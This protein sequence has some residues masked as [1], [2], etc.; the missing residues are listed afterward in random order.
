MRSF[1]SGV[2]WCFVLCT[3][4]VVQGQAEAMA[5]GLGDV[6]KKAFVMGV[7][8]PDGALSAGEW[9][10]LTRHFHAVTP[11][12][13]MKPVALQPEEGRF[14]W[15]A[16]D[17]LV[18]EADRRKLRVNG[19]V[20]VWHEQCP[21]WFFQQGD[22]EAPREQVLKR[23]REHVAAVVGRYAGKIQSWDVV[24]EALA[25]GEGFLRDSK[26]SRSLGEDYVIEGFRAARLAD[27][28]AE[29]CYNDYN[30]EDPPKREKAVRLLRLLK[31]RGALPDAIGIQGHWLLGRVPFADI[32]AAILA[33]HAE[34]VKIMVTELDID[35]VP[36][37][38]QS[39]DLSVRSDD[40]ANPFPDQLPAEMDELLARDYAQ[41]FALFV[42]HRDKISRVTLWGLHDG[43]S[44]LN[45]WPS[46]RTNH[47][48]LWDRQLQPKPALKAILGTAP[49]NEKR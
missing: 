42:K 30:I 24:N 41:L 22:S 38:T 27:P 10:L 37:D 45:H 19:H 28:A 47:P 6:F 31:D 21:D 4:S 1:L 46:K 3:S 34:G 49:M 8:M 20:L 14:R 43:R 5:H 44:W 23:L 26:W 29:L 40:R 15:E 11:E 36:R 12:N 13:S 9:V 7:A 32:E 18:A 16:A 25:D 33:F 48:L 17:A 35:V 39:A 2:I